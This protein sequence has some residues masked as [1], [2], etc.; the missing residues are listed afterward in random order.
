MS[1]KRTVTKTK[2]KTRKKSDVSP[3]VGLIITLTTIVLSL[4]GL[5]EFGLFGEILSSIVRVFFG[6]VPILFFSL[7]IIGSVIWILYKKEIKLDNKSIIGLIL[8]FIAIEV[9]LVLISGNQLKGWAVFDQFFKSINGI[10]NRSVEAQGGLFGAIFYS[11]FSWLFDKSGTILITVLL[12]VSGSILL[13]YQHVNKVQEKIWS[14]PFKAKSL[15]KKP[16]QKILKD[17]S[18]VKVLNQKSVE[19]DDLPQFEP[20]DMAQALKNE[21]KESEKKLFIDAEVK[22]ETVKV[23]KPQKIEP[24]PV[25]ETDSDASEFETTNYVLPSLSLLDRTTGPKGSQANSSSAS[26]KGERLVHILEQFGIPTTLLATHIGPAVTKFELKLDTSVK[27]SRIASLQDNIMME[28]AVKEIR[29]EAPIPGKNAVGVEIP[30][31]EMTPVRLIELLEDVPE[32]LQDEK[33]LVALGKNLMGKNMFGTLNRMPHLLVAGATGA[34]KS[35]AIN[36]MIATILLRTKPSE[37]KLL[38]IDPKKVEFQVFA[39]I[40][41][42][43][44]PVMSDA[45]EAAKGLNVVVKIMDNRYDKFAAEGARNIASYNELAS[46]NLLLK[47][48]PHIVVIIDELADLMAV[49]GKEVE[50][51]IQRITQLARAAGIHLVVATQ[52]PSVD[53]ITGVIKANIPSRIAFAVSSGTD[54]RTILDTTGAERLLGYGDMLYQPFG[55]P[56]PTR[57]QGVFISDDEVARIAQETKKQASPRYDDAFMNLEGA[58]DNEGFVASSDDPLYEEVKEYVIAEQKASTSLLQRRFGIGYNRAAR[59]IDALEEAGV[60]GPVAGSKPRDVYLKPE[61]QVEE[62]D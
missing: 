30:N 4:I 49:A 11:L 55:E 28:L 62:L 52:R 10:F 3:A 9:L 54:S 41:H 19:F 31:I 33:L 60:I 58:S 17:K 14:K 51:S 25:S 15:V 29:I 18:D 35:V 43:I 23:E 21:K 22:P 36:S 7:L 57:I 2:P 12:F 34:G 38:L 42:L 20:I 32:K 53:V 44:A 5:L 61:P 45:V 13:G 46:R 56:H 6:S 47:P 1:K 50:A 59:M 48:M 39:D 8:I 40:P 24:V 16:S 26:S 27:V 37:V